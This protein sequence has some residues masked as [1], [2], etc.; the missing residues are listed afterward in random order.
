MAKLDLHSTGSDRFTA[1]QT[2]SKKYADTSRE[3]NL[4]FEKYQFFDANDP[5]HNN[6]NEGYTGLYFEKQT[7]ILE[8]LN[9]TVSCSNPMN[10]ETI[11][12]K[13]VSTNVWAVQ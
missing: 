5:T 6:L 12:W 8:T 1:N 7:G 11:I 9:C 3:R 13:L 10:V 4:W 2:N